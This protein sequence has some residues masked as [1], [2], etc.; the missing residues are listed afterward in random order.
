[1]V[2][3]CHQPRRH[4]LVSYADGAE[5]YKRYQRENCRTAL[6]LGVHECFLFDRASL[7]PYYE[8]INKHILDVPLGAGLWSWKAICIFMALQMLAPGDTAFYMDSGSY[9]VGDVEV[10][11]E[12]AESGENDVMLFADCFWS[13]EQ[14]S[15][16]QALVLL[17]GDKYLDR[18]MPLAAWSLWHKT[19]FAELFLAR[20]LTF[21]QDLRILQSSDFQGFALPQHPKF[22]EHRHD[23]V[24]LIISAYHANLTL[25]RDPSDYGVGEDCHRRYPNSD[26]YGHLVKEH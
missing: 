24:P 10:L 4:V 14:Y 6:G 11:F 19:P 22:R 21:S 1:M 26:F 12:H 16:R 20:W 8:A 15:Q 2:G 23:M 13:V 17:D 9:L 3:T 18:Q 7:P 5:K 25:F